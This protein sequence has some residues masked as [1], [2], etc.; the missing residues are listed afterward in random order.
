M[1]HTEPQK[2]TIRWLTKDK[3][4]ID[5]IRKRF[6]MP[7]YTTL[8]GWSPALI[9]E[10]DIELFEE[11]GRRKFFKIMPYKWCKNGGTFSFIFRQK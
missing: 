11:C 9:N 4:A 3:D 8:N 7:T 6:N 1:T 5:A 10:E 2:L